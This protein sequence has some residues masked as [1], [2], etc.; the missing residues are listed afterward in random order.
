MP[1]F[2]PFF[3]ILV[4][5]FTFLC[6]CMVRFR[7][8]LELLALYD[9]EVTTDKKGLAR[10][11]GSILMVIAIIQAGCGIAGLLVG[12]LVWTGLAFVGFS[13]FL[14]IVLALGT[15]EYSK[16]NIR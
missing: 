9:A 2:I 8:K 12:N 4:G 6:G 3:F 13:L 1:T 14:T 10:W 16:H 5:C 15:A 11:A 7:R